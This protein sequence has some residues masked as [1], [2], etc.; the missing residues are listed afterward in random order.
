MRL[1]PHTLRR[2]CALARR[3]DS[4]R[5]LLPSGAIHGGTSP[6][7]FRGVWLHRSPPRPSEQRL[8]APR[9]GPRGP[10]DRGAPHAKACARDPPGLDADSPVASRSMRSSLPAGLPLLGLSKDRPSIVPRRRVRLPGPPTTCE[11]WAGPLRGTTAGRSRV[12]PS[13]FRTTSAAFSS[14]TVQVCCALLPILGFA[15]FLPVAKRASS[16][17]VPALRSFPS[18][19]SGDTGSHQHRGLASRMRPSL[20]APSP[21]ALPP[22]PSLRAP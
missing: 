13:W 10:Y 14:A 11:T 3:T 22:R 7:R 17:R 15:V 18:A 21:L 20:D 2:G 12:P 4:R 5:P 9:R 1:A 19:D 8:P 16:R 6:G